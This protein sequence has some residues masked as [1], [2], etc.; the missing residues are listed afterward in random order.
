MPITDQ[1]DYMY[2]DIA[3]ERFQFKFNPKE[4]L[5]KILNA[6]RGLGRFFFRQLRR[7]NDLRKSLMSKINLGA[8][9]SIAKMRPAKSLY[10][11]FMK[12]FKGEESFTLAEESIASV[13]F[14]KKR[15]VAR[16]LKKTSELEDICDNYVTRLLQLEDEILLAFE[17]N[18]KRT[19]TLA[20][21]VMTDVPLTENE[22]RF[23]DRLKDRDTDE[24]QFVKNSEYIID[25]YMICAGGNGLQ[26]MMDTIDD[27]FEDKEMEKGIYEIKGE[28]AN[29]SKSN[30]ITADSVKNITK[31][32]VSSIKTA[33]AK[34]YI[35]DAT[36][37][38][39]SVIED[40]KSFGNLLMSIGEERGA[41]S[42]NEFGKVFGV[43]IKDLGNI[44][45][46]I[47][48]SVEFHEKLMMMKDYDNFK[49]ELKTRMTE[50]VIKNGATDIAK[51]IA[52]A[53][54]GFLNPFKKATQAATAAIV[55]S[56]VSVLMVKVTKLANDS[57]DLTRK[58]ENYVSTLIAMN[59]KMRLN[60]E[61]NDIGNGLKMYT[62]TDAMRGNSEKISD[63]RA[64]ISLIS[65]QAKISPKRLLGKA[66]ASIKDLLK[67]YTI[68]KFKIE[69]AP[70]EFGN[71][72]QSGINTGLED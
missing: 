16:V 60:G 5:K 68:D 25:E 48:S 40:G 28:V 12:T 58:L 20:K 57:Y 1:M 59:D 13:A 19:Q 52:K 71:A 17:K 43:F 22:R 45:S 7:L 38:T 34:S 53:G 47:T 31:G 2:W 3:T 37:A 70:E 32:A 6:L 54:F 33:D 9:K 29:I 50:K 8:L 44:I 63:I 67:Y 46:G 26:K 24:D 30:V 69:F 4:I 39:L 55:V 49:N 23:L 41:T 11:R 42:V 56:D 14:E 72:V 64:L 15:S 61:P 62:E 35:R 27:A 65:V 36:N 18:L 51:I 66:N 10:F 21:K